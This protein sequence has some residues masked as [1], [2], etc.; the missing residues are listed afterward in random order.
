MRAIQQRGLTRPPG[1]DAKSRACQRQDNGMRH[2]CSGNAIASNLAAALRRTLGRALPAIICAAC[3]LLFAAHAAEFPA[4]AVRI[5]V[6]TTTGGSL[7]YVTRLVAQELGK[8]WRHGIVVNNRPG[9]GTLI[10]N[11]IVAKAVPDGHTILF[12]SSSLTINAAAYATLPFDPV[13]DFAP[14]TLLSYSAWVLVANAALPV[15]SVKDLIALAKAKPGQLSYASAGNGSGIHF[16]SELLNSMA[17]IKLLHVPYK[18]VVPAI[19]GVISDQVSVAVTGL[20]SAMPLATTGKLHLLAVTGTRRSEILP[21]VPT[22]GETVP[23]YEFNNWH[24]VLVPRGTPGNIVTQ[25]HADIARTLQSREVKQL[26]F[27]Q[28]I[29][30]VASA[31]EQFGGVIRQE[32]SKYTRLAKDIGARIN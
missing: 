2:R 11:D 29:E 21:D 20:P 14:V 10:G 13:R 3:P 23:G 27:T 9:A 26:L 17:G 1:K 28:S 30:P 32:I 12:T 18:G 16:A 31:P 24:G 6:P 22:I 19:Q 5:V 7:D 15:R 4:K 25:L 8:S